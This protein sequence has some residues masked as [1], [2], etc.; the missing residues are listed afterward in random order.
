MPDSWILAFRFME[1]LQGQSDD[2]LVVRGLPREE[3]EM[4]LEDLKA[5]RKLLRDE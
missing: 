3:V 4:V 5:K 1:R 2:N